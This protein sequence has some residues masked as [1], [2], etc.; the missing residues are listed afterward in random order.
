MVKPTLKIKRKGLK[1]G[2]VTDA[3]RNKAWQRLVI[4]NLENEFDFVI[5]HDDTMEKNTSNTI[6]F[7][8]TET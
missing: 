2:I 8:F 5:T 7:S 6:L 1:L 4:T 3:P